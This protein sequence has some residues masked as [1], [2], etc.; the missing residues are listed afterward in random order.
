MHAAMKL[1]TI[2]ASCGLAL[3]LALAATGAR[4]DVAAGREERATRKAGRKARGAKST[5]TSA[6]AR[7]PAAPDTASRAPTHGIVR[8]QLWPRFKHPPLDGPL[9]LT[10]TFGEYR[11]GRFHA[12]LDFSTGEHVGLR[13][14]RAARWL[15]RAH[16]LIGRGLRPLALPARA[17]WATRIVLAHLDAFD[18]PLASY[19]AAVQDSSG[20]YEQD[21]WPPPSLMPIHAGQRLGWSGQSGIGAPHLHLEV[22]RGDMAINPLLA[23]A[24][25]DD[26]DAPV[27]GAIAIEPR[28]EG[29]LINGA[30]ATVV[31]H[32]PGTGMGPDT[33]LAIVGAALDTVRLNG[34]ARVAVEAHDPGVRRADMEPYE[35]EMSWSGR[36]VACRFDS[37]SWATDMPEGEIVYDRGR[38]LPASAHGV[39]LC[40]PS[41]L[42]PR[43]IRVTPESTSVTGT[44]GAIP[45]DSLARVRIV[46]RDFAGH[47][48]RREFMLRARSDAEHMVLDVPKDQ[49]GDVAGFRW[50]VPRRG[51][52]RGHDGHRRKPRRLGAL[53]RTQTHHAGRGLEAV[54]ARA[55]RSGFG[56]G[57]AARGRAA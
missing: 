7:R 25:V 22:R 10:G 26:R 23:G 1:A 16:S 31:L 11:P 4:G 28:D 39:R 53:G 5:A 32:S 45:A 43:V 52:V 8:P 42:R 44:L 14:L 33:P 35:I 51:A 37:I 20:Q 21:L 55:A 18:E 38:A 30:V 48:A 24:E 17:R 15:H 19:V 6:N 29:S 50:S 41:A 56:G 3:A 9:V 13:G 54:V 27:I 12:G 34:V 47:E 49:Q 46:V 36:T 57:D 2:V 40:V